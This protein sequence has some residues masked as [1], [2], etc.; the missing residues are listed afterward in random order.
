MSAS[1]TAHPVCP[2]WPV[3]NCVRKAFT[4]VELLLVIA[5][6][7]ILVGLLLPAVQTA[8]EAARGMHCGNNMHQIGIAMHNYESV[9]GVF[10]VGS[11][12]SNFVS[13]FVGILPFVE[14]NNNFQQ[15][16]FSLSYA[17]AYNSSV[18]NQ[19]I[20]TFLCPSMTIPRRVPLLEARETGGPSSYLFCEGTDDYMRVAD[21]LFGLHWPGFGYSNPARGFR[22]IQDG[23]S[24]TFM[25]GETVYDYQDYRWP[26]FAPPEFAGTIRY[27][28]ARWVVGYP[29]ISL[30]TTL[31]PFNL[32]VAAAMGGF[33]SM[34]PGG[35]HFLYADG[36]T[37]F[38]SEQVHVE[39]LN[40]AS[41]LSGSELMNAGDLDE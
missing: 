22:D 10:P 28:T 4:L 5:I 29:R 32:H 37:H 3:N 1:S 19:R 15:W 14:Q 24:N 27:G 40:A 34:H 31:K 25:A 26:S 9:Y 30:G 33:A 35:A 21:G 23:A 6:I 13:P 38:I 41:T 12:Q 17:S 39:I 16:D 36:S 20:G 2:N 18:A 11:L 7:G 8:R